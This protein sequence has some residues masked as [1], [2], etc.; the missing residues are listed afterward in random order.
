VSGEKWGMP[1]PAGEKKNGSQEPKE[2]LKK[3]SKAEKKKS[4]GG[5]ERNPDDGKRLKKN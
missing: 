1:A 5:R 4:R 2:E 3:K